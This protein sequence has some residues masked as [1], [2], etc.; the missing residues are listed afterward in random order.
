MKQLTSELIRTDERFEASIYILTAQRDALAQKLQAAS[1]G[2]APDQAIEITTTPAADQIHSPGQSAALS[3]PDFQTSPPTV[4]LSLDQ[5][6]A[7]A[8]NLAV[9]VQ[10]HFARDEFS[11]AEADDRKLLQLVPKNNIAL[12]NL[13]VIEFLE[14][15]LAEAQTNITTALSVETDDAANLALRGKIEFDRGDDTAAVLDLFRAAQ[16]D[17]KNAGTRNDLGLTLNH[18]GHETCGRGG[19]Q[20]GD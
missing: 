12:A 5:W 17:P 8:S 9:S 20:P 11:L 2:G 16:L 10:R 13:A 19:L 6:P 7:A 1:P 4:N 14:N 15:H 18:L 3:L